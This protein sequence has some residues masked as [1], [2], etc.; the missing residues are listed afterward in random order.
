M[1]PE[2]AAVGQDDGSDA[3]F[4]HDGRGGIV[5]PI[6]RVGQCRR[7]AGQAV[8]IVVVV[9]VAIFVVDDVHVAIGGRGQT[10]PAAP[11]PVAA[12]HDPVAD[13][14]IMMMMMIQWLVGTEEETT[15]AEASKGL[16]LAR[17]LMVMPWQGRPVVDKQ[18]M[19]VSSLPK[20]KN[21]IPRMDKQMLTELDC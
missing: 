8:V 13:R 5:P 2:A 6:E 20:T 14:I 17:L 18:Q 4:F 15:L 10:G 7:A 11:A 12:A 9:V 3:A 19:T 21:K 16:A 1:F